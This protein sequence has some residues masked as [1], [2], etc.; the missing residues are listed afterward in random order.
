MTPAIEIHRF[1]ITNLL[2]PTPD[3][4]APG[5]LRAVKSTVR[6]TTEVQIDR[7]ASDH[8]AWMV[9]TLFKRVSE[10]DSRTRHRRTQLRVEDLHCV[11]R[12]HHRKFRPKR[13]RHFLFERQS[14]QRKRPVL[15]RTET[16]ALPTSLRDQV[17]AGRAI[18]RRLGP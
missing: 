9:R 6:I 12:H 15:Q 7:L 17:R 5:F 1:D 10:K 14:R 16:L 13:I 3:N 4:L 8:L 2:L 18:R 11:T